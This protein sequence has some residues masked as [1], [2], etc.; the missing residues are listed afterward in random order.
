MQEMKDILCIYYSR[1]GN[2]KT[3]V[4]DIAKVLDAEV[5]EIHDNV[6][7][8]GIIGFI[9]SGMHAS[10][11]HPMHT[12]G[13]K[14][15]RPLNEYRLVIV[16]SPVWAGRC[17]SPVRVFMRKHGKKFTNVCYVLTRGTSKRY[18]E[19]YEQLDQYTNTPHIEGVSLHC[20]GVGYHFW[21]EDF[22]TR[23][24]GLLP[25]LKAPEPFEQ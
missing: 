1:T 13:F 7:R 10:A 18:E 20:K 8:N 15:A 25:T 19:V 24:K 4:E 17:C 2:T 21:V 14:T 16:A 11:K 5:V 22:L 6:E 3:A 9:K 12:I 23:V